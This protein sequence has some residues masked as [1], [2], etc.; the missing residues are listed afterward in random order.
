M[1][2]RVEERDGR[3]CVVKITDGSTVHCHDS[4]SMAEAQVR[5]LYASEGKSFSYLDIE[6]EGKPP[7]DNATDALV[8]YGGAVK[9]LGDGRVGGYGVLFT[10]ADDP[11]L[12][13]D[14]FTKSTDLELNGRESLLAMWDHGLDSV[15]KRRRLGRATY[16]V[17]DA[18]VWFETKLNES[19]DYEKAVYG[20]AKAGKLG[21]STGSAPHL[22]ERVPVKKAFELKSWP[23]IEVSLTHMPVEPR[24][25]AVPLKSIAHVELKSLLDEVESEKVPPFTTKALD[26]ALA[27]AY[28]D[29]LD[30]HSL[31][32]ATA[33]EELIAHYTK[34]ATALDVLSGRLARKQEFR[35]IKDGR[36]F[37]QRRVDKMNELIAQLKKLAEHPI[38]LASEFEKMVK[39]AVTTR[40]QRNALQQAAEFQY[41]QFQ[42]L[43]ESHNG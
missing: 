36:A 35:A 40:D 27:A 8:F 38:A 37:S 1:P 23:I 15:L 13:G 29:D 4:R 43:K 9:A 6:S 24:T 12:Q 19:D 16:R 14:Y 21:W 33:V 26:A 42:Q 18:G 17:D 5:A 2:W 32:V 39:E 30:T 20:L 34:A 10:T 3:F 28:D 22:V 11:D 7:M 31:K 25:A 41:N